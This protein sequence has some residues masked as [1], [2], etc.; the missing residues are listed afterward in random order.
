ML[1]PQFPRPAA[2]KILGFVL[3]GLCVLAIGGTVFVQ[4]E[5][6][7]ESSAVSRGARLTEEAGCYACH[8]R[9]EEEPRFNLRQTA[10]DKWRDKNNPSF[11]EGDITEVKVLV[12]WIT[13][14]VP[15]AD[16]EDHKKLF[17]RM[18]AYRDRLTPGEIEDIAAWILAEGLKLRVDPA[19]PKAPAPGAPL[20]PDQLFVAGD[21]L[22]RRHGCYQC[23]GELGQGGVA[24]PDSFKGYIPGFQGKDF[25]KL[26][27]NG[28]RT[29]IL[30]WIDHGRG[31]A[32]ESG[33]LGRIAK[34][35]FDGQAIPM[36]GYRD[37]LSVAEKE[38]LADYL[39]L[40]NKTGPLPASEI[41]R[42]NRL[43][44]P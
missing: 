21:A 34:K 16:A 25:L 5:R 33:P 12:D 7:P 9:S 40:L 27:A 1:S 18:P 2:G 17:I 38:L 26:T 15:A 43:L 19:A 37:H 31:K 41:E 36:P 29:E 22:S 8:G 20:T 13:H 32:I 11:W 4:V 44:N 10:P 42:L 24:N 6:Q 35:F 23:H 39:L 30:H 28:D 3:L 14:G